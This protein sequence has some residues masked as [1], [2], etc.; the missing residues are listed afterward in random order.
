MY[1]FA[2]ELE[3][4]PSEILYLGD[5]VTDYYSARDAGAIFIG[6]L[7]G[8]ADETVWKTEDPDMITVQYAGDVIRLL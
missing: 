7:S 4:E 6:V 1:Y 2:D 5:N 8:S 3:V